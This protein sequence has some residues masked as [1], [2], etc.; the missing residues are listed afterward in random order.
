M[1]NIKN[2]IGRIVHPI[3]SLY[4]TEKSVDPAS[5]WG[6]TWEKWENCFLLGAG[7]SYAIN[8]SD[9]DNNGSVITHTHTITSHSHDAAQ[10]AS[11][12]NNWNFYAYNPSKDVL[13]GRIINNGEGAERTW[14]ARAVSTDLGWASAGIAA[15]SMSFASSGSS[16]TNANMPPY[17]NVHIWHRIR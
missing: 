6:G 4:I 11:T 2:F 15:A 8:T 16:A 12:G 9:G 13:K 3:G 10:T 14:A 17:K 1:K 7:S 5:L